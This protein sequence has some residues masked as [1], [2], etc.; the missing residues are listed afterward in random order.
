MRTSQNSRQ[1]WHIHISGVVQG[2]GFRPYVYSLAKHHS[3]S[4]W[5]CNTSSGVEIEVFGPPESLR[6]FFESLPRQAPPLA[7]IDSCSWSDIPYRNTADFVIRHSH[8]QADESLPV[9][10]D[11]GTCEECR[12]E[13]FDPSDRRYRYP[14]INCTQCG[15]RFTIVK[16]IPYDRPATTMAKFEMCPACATEYG[17]PMSRRFHAQPNACSAC[18]PQVRLLSRSSVE[19]S[20]ESHETSECSAQVDCIEES[21]IATARALLRQGKILAIKGIGGFHLACDPTHPGAVCELRRRKGRVDKPF[22]LMAR[23]LEE[24][25]RFCEVGPAEERLLLS[26]Q[27]PI[28][29]LKRKPSSLDSAGEES[30][31]LEIAP[32]QSTL[33][34]MLPYTPLHELILQPEG[35]FPGALVM[36]SGN[37]REEPIATTDEEAFSRLAPL[38]DAYLTH[39]RDIH[40]SCDDSVVRV[41]NGKELPIRRSRGYAPYPVK[42]PWVLPPLLAVGGELKNTFCVTRDHYAY[43][44]QHI[45]DMENYETFASFEMSV[46]HF[47]RLF[48]IRPEL[49]AYDLHPDYLATQYAKTRA[50]REGLDAVAIQHHHAHIAACM[51]EHDLKGDQPVIGVAFDGTGYGTDGTIWGG[52]FLVADYCS[53]ERTAH[54]KYVLLPGGDLAVLKPYRIALSYLHQ[55][56]IPWT[57]DLPCV[58]I[59]SSVELA[60]V[61]AQI[62]NR[63]NAPS[64]SSMGRLFDAVASLLAVRQQVNYEGQAAIELEAIAAPEEKN[65]YPVPQVQDLTL[66]CTSIIDSIVREIRMGVSPSTI[67]A[68]FHNTI[69]SMVRDTSCGIRKERG[70]NQVV[71]SG[72]VFQNVTLL[73]ITVDLLRGEGFAVYTHRLVPPN[74][75]GL[76][77]GQAIIASRMRNA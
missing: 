15:P 62:R 4:G 12:K 22:A 61:S 70:I 47:E 44:S 16:D 10:S 26:P 35:D 3:L 27:R 30:L 66:D 58:G 32:G 67:S 50:E 28:V 2:V 42:L 49:L 24:I 33:G 40:L 74:D 71:L 63:V 64:T 73:Q 25:R 6:S 39:N 48:R 53:F 8:S 29:L 17:D 18:G 45:G 36:T 19:S 5:V 75:G 37:R 55:A 76:A 54:L 59:A 13:L 72:G 77:L 46:S 51:A 52:E 57:A 60:S 14:F 68:R 9:S 11:A 20:E 21:A 1:G 41:F 69:A 56:G 38:A 43:M 31:S 34:F 7:R 65:T 23:T